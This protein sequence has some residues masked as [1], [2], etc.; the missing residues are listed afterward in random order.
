VL[1]AVLAIGVSTVLAVLGAFHA[2][3]NNDEAFHVM[4]LRHYFDDGW[5]AV[6]WDYRGAGPGSEGTNTFVYAPVTALL[7]HA[8]TVLFGGESWGVVSTSAHAYDLR[9]LGVV[10]IGLVGIAAVVAIGRILMQHWRWGLVAAGALSAIPMWTGHEM[11]N[12]KDI[13]VATGHTLVTLALLCFVRERPSRP[14]ERAAR[15]CCLVGGLVL[16]LGTRPGMWPGLLAMLIVAVTG[17]LLASPFRRALVGVAEIAAGCVTTVLVLL[18]V[19]PNVFSSPR[20]ALANTAERSSSFLDG[21][22]TDRLYLPEHLGAEIPTLLLLFILTGTVAGLVTTLRAIRHDP[23]PA[24]RI[25]LVGVQAF[26]L[27]VTAIVLGSDLYS[28]LR[29]LLFMLPAMAVLAA[30]GMARTDAWW[31]ERRPGRFRPIGAVAAVALTLPLVDQVALHP[32]ELVYVNLASD[33]MVRELGVKD[34]RPVDYWR[35]SIPELVDGLELDRPLLCKAT[36][37][38]RTGIAYPFINGFAAD[39]PTRSIDCREEVYGPLVPERLPIQREATLLEFDAVFLTKPL[40]RNCTQR[41]QVTRW[42]HGAEHLLSVLGRCTVEPARLTEQGVRADSALIA[43]TSVHD[44]WRFAVNGWEQW[45]GVD[46]IW[47][48][49]PQA[50]LLLDVRD[51]CTGG[52]S[53][54]LDTAGVPDDLVVTVDGAQVTTTDDET[55]LLIPLSAATAARPYVEVRF[56]RSSGANLGLEVSRLRPA[57]RP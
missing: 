43:S 16:T 8:W 29:Q 23:V 56:T 30:F 53:L 44:L 50:A 22:R 6:D 49:L 55:R 12:V 2:G 1:A 41:A 45:P 3:V 7:L 37:S 32:Y 27:P 13:P 14:T 47:S 40:P 9:H 17:V 5:Y 28:G 38:F 18:A 51:V 20:E 21:A 33:A 36:T 10:L 25:A 34:V 52:C 4:R 39:S 48:A 54:A 31:R 24:T 26:L 57:V 11:F 19:Y 15:W 35:V 42:Q 46:R